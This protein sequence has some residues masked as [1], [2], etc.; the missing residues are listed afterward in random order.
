MPFTHSQKIGLVLLAASFLLM[1]VS[2][3]WKRLPVG[4]KSV[5]LGAHCFFLHPFFLAAAWTRLYGFPRDPRLWVCFFVHD[6]GYI[7]KPNMDGPE[8]ETHPLLGARIMHWFDSSW[9]VYEPENDFHMVPAGVCRETYWR[10]LALCH[11]RYYAKRLNKPF[12]RVCVADKLAFIL[13]PRWL[14]LPMVK[15]TGEVYEYLEKARNADTQAGHFKAGDYS[16]DMIGWHEELCRYMTKWVEAHKN[17]E[18]DTWTSSN[19]H[20]L[21]RDGQTECDQ[22]GCCFNADGTCGSQPWHLAVAA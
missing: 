19:R 13:T 15:L 18:Q 2:E 21:V 5:L 9:T 12:S 7:G 6:L 8:G 22:C 1:F 14:Y 4:T 10:D 17:G 20:R 3:I 11:S 16:E